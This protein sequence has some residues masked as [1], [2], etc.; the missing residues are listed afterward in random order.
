MAISTQSIATASAR[1]PW[2]V[3]ALWI[4]GLVASFMLIGNLLST[5][6][7]NEADI[8]SDPE[9]E[10]GTRLLEERLRGPTRLNEAVII[11]SSTLTVDSPGFQSYVEGIQGEIDA[12]GT[13]VVE[14]SASFYSSGAASLVSDDRR[15]TLL[16]LVMAGDVDEAAENVREVLAIVERANGEGEFQV[17]VSGFASVGE[18]F[19][20]ALEEDLQRSE[21]LTLPVALLILVVVFG[22]LAAAL[23]PIAVAAIAIV[24]AIALTA[25]IGQQF[26][27]AF[28]VTNMIL[29][30][31]L[32]VGIDYCLFIVSRFREERSHGRD[33]EEA[34]S[35][36]AATAGR[37]VLFSGIT[38][39]VALLGLL[40]VPQTIFRSLS[41]GAILVV[42]AAVAAS[43]TL[44][45]A[46]LSLLGDRVNSL[47]IPFIQH[48]QEA[49]RDEAS[50]GFWDRVAR[51]VMAHPVVSV[52]LATSLLVAVTIPYFGMQVGFSGVSTLPDSFQ[53]KQ[54]FDILEREFGGGE[55]YP[56]EVVID[57]PVNSAQVQS[58]V[59]KL[60]SSLQGDA[61]FGASHF[62]AN[63]AGDLGLL[64]I[65]MA[66]DPSA[67]AATNAI[68]RLRGEYIPAAFDGVDADVLV[69]GISAE[70]LDF[71]NL[72][73]DYQPL[74][75]VFVL[76]LSFLI[77]MMVFRSIVVPTKAIL[78]NLL[79]VG[80]AYGLIVLV[81]QE[82]FATGLLG[83]Q[84]VEAI[85]AWLP[86]FL[87]SI[88]FGLSMD[89]HVFLLSRI[90]ERY[91]QTGNNTEAVAFGLR[92]TGRLITGAALI[93][94][95]VF[96]GFALGD[97][98]MFQQMGF[99]LG[100]AV[101]IDATLI[102]CV[103]VPASMRL[104]GKWNWYLPSVLSWLPHLGIEAPELPEAHRAPEPVASRG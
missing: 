20:K 15:T 41:G 88:L 83:F 11:Q 72:S 66:A 14:S 45:P 21:F 61:V 23:L 99:G 79:S 87:F 68:E 39:V 27:F 76:G 95:A 9:S 74:V 5:A 78:M 98:V 75:V 33:K 59:E 58:A 77:L 44:L 48:V 4:V 28:F 92:S 17:Y 57:G 40:I 62:E 30:M 6:V 47:R 53:S 18:D 1:H 19:N 64:S 38:V 86:L 89:Y 2:R 93:M 22:A 51:I 13:D 102:R 8:T 36:S 70:N 3:I 34:I 54:G 37:A 65:Q 67:P 81:F 24:V 96:G 26:Q 85:E 55:V 63:N 80:A 82:G 91:D 100:V 32:A 97:L 50:G 69:A 7:T 101:L 46:M 25:V 12:L 60:K 16:P 49:S 35:I 10:R 94:V 31:G 71:F 84:Q 90:R 42:L 52:V 29:M 103:L 56:A 43:L 104:L 73:E